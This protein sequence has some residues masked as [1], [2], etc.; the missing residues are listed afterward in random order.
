MRYHGRITKSNMATTTTLTIPVDVELTFTSPDGFQTSPEAGRI[1]KDIALEASR[2]YWKFGPQEDIGELAWLAV[3]A[4]E[5]GEVAQEMTRHHVP[6]AS[7]LTQ[8]E[9]RQYRARLR[10]EIVQ[11]AAVAARMVYVIDRA[12]KSDG[13]PQD[14]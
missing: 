12:A 4:E 8:R 9:Y 1:L 5:F 13:D 14:G 7:T 6:P 2:A 3:L 10:A 11:V